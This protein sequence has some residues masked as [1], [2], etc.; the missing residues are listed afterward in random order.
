LAAAVGRRDQRHVGLHR[1]RF[2]LDELVVAAEVAA[3]LLGMRRRN[4]GGRGE[5]KGAED[6]ERSGHG[7]LLAGMEPMFLGW[8][9]DDSQN[10]AGPRTADGQMTPARFNP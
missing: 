1:H 6:G 4:S 2:P 10:R 8:A 3:V 9:F 5:E 7:L